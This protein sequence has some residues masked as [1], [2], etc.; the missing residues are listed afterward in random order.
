MLDNK[1]FKCYTCKRYIT[2]GHE[3]FWRMCHE[4]GEYNLEMRLRKAGLK[5]YIALVTGARIKI[6]FH[7]A[8]KLLR[9]GATVIA[10]TRFPKDAVM[11]YTRETDFGEWK[12]RLIVC[13]LDLLRVDLM[14]V[15]VDFMYKE[16]KYID[17]I[18]NNAAQ[19]VRKPD[20]YYEK[21]IKNESKLFLDESIRILRF[22]E[23]NLISGSNNEIVMKSAPDNSV[24]TNSWVLTNQDISMKEFLEV[25][26]I[27]VTAPFYLN[28]RLKQLLVSSPNKNRFII[29]VSSVEGQFARKKPSRYHIHSNMAKASLNMMTKTISS[30]YAKDRIYVY[31]VDPGWVSNQFPTKWP[32]INDDNFRPPIQYEDAAARLCHPIFEWLEA[33]KPEAGLFLKDYRKIEW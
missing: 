20:E 25:Q 1:G 10:A 19:T 17:I 23:S 6:G 26:L 21:L 2:E 11:R 18:V 31:S 15:F 28:S 24:S 9:N 4:C 27:N 22:N 16:F 33:E 5:G 8:L 30:D 13:G 29:N 7:T 3:E 14:D 12:D 32:T